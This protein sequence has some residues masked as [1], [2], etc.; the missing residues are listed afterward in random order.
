MKRQIL[1]L[2]LIV[3]FIG[4]LWPDK[5]TTSQTTDPVL[6]GAGDIADGADMDLSGAMATAVLLES[7]PNAMVF[8]DGDL[9]HNNGTE[10]DY[11]KF[12]TPTWG[13]FRASTIPVAGN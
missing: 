2:A 6:V 9:P 7:F 13:R 10:S 8:A 3:A 11:A 5:E 4:V 12:Y 1:L